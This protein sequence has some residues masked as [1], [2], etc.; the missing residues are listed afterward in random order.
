MTSRTDATS[1]VLESS[2]KTS[3]NPTAVRPHHPRTDRSIC[4]FDMTWWEES[5]NRF[6]LGKILRKILLAD[7]KRLRPEERAE[8]GRRNKFQFERFSSEQKLRVIRFQL[9]PCLFRI[10]SFSSHHNPD[11]GI[12]ATLG[13]SHSSCLPKQK[14]EK[15]GF[16]WWLPDRNLPR[17]NFRYSKEMIVTKEMVKE[18][19]KTWNSGLHF[20]QK[21]FTEVLLSCITRNRSHQSMSRS[22]WR[23]FLRL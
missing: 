18:D 2:W 13:T 5:E 22:C 6:L 17:I 19:M 9:V 12:I 8:C 4:T 11:F 15:H 3:A 21:R 1:G 7:P 16:N 20:R 14:H 23:T 10:F